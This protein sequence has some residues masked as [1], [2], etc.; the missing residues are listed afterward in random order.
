[1][2]QLVEVP[3]GSVQLNDARR[4]DSRTVELREF[5]I[6]AY[7]VTATTYDATTAQNPTL[8]ATGV[9]WIDAAQWCNTAS[10]TAGITPAYEIHNGEV[11][12][13]LNSDGFR[14]P[15]EAE[16]EYAS[17]AGSTGPRYGELSQ[18][19]WTDADPIDASQPVGL[20]RPN[21]FG[22]YDTLGN[23]WE[24][25]WDR[26]DPARYSDYRVFKG[27][28]WADPEWSCRVGVRRGDS[29]VAKLEDVGFRVVRGAAGPG[30]QGWSEAEDRARAAI[31]GPRPVGWT[32][33]R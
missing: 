9:R 14:L 30:G 22:L 5:R 7:P 26:L 21:D 31:T 6:G 19:A 3:A 27:G 8:P 17:R 33:L 13:D 18:I 29:P 1:M 15:T 10:E 24:W 4:G 16:W 11:V 23:A 28:G 12:W 32:P 20:K 2:Q 25:C